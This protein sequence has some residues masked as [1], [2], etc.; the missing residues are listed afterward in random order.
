LPEKA[1]LAGGNMDRVDGVGVL[2]WVW[3]VVL[4]F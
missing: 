3:W 4:R 2:R 1:R